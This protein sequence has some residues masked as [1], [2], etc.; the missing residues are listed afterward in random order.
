MATKAKTKVEEIIENEEEVNLEI[1]ESDEAEEKPVKAVKTKK[2]FHGEVTTALNVR[3]EPGPDGEIIGFFSKGQIIEC[4]RT[5][6]PNWFKVKAG[7]LS[8]Y[9]SANYINIL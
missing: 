2:G 4:E 1:G 5:D 7:E 9:S 8:G 6:N 3:K